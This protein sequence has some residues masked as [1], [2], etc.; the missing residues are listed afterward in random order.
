MITVF[1]SR[2]IALT[3]MICDINFQMNLLSQKRMNLVNVGMALS[4]G[5]LTQEEI[6]GSN[7]YTQ[8]GLAGAVAFGNTLSQTS[9]QTMVSRTP[10]AINFHDAA[11]ERI[12]AQLASQEKVIDLKM[13]GLETQLNMFNK[14]LE[15]VEKGEEKAIEKATPKYA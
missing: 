9:G 7:A 4:D 13:K 8:Q 10:Q 11:R 12:E 5:Q 2:K 1:A 15:S 6:Q 3:A 14:E